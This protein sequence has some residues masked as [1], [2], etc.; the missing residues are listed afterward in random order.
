M[1]VLI[2]QGRCFFGGFFSANVVKTFQLSKQ[3]SAET[4]FKQRFNNVLKATLYWSGCFWSVVGTL[5]VVLLTI[6]PKGPSQ[7]DY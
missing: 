4:L 2:V 1:S 7:S 5:Y 6:L 3:R